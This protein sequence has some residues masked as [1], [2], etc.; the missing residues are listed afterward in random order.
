M[1]SDQ[2]FKNITNIDM[3]LI[4][5]S[6]SDKKLIN[7]TIQ[8]DIEFLKENNLIGYKLQIL[9]EELDMSRK[10]VKK[11]AENGGN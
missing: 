4:K 2:D 9:V 1:F 8:R 5:L 10:S 11:I 3:S 7:F 6:Q